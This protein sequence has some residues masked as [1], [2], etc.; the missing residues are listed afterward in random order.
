MRTRC[1]KRVLLMTLLVV[2]F[3]VPLATAQ[4]VCCNPMEVGCTCDDFG[5]CYETP[6]P[7]VI[8]LAGGPWRF[9]GPTHGVRFDIRAIGR[10]ENVSWTTRDANIGFL[11]LDLNGNGVID[12][13]SEL[14]GD[15]TRLSNGRRA[16]NGFA[17]L[18]QY[19]LNS[20]GVIDNSDPVWPRLLLWTDNNHD[21]VSQPEEFERVS[22]SGIT[23]IHLEHHWT[24][25][26]D[27]NGN[28]FRYAGTIDVGERVST[29]YDIYLVL[30]H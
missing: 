11:A 27:P 26:V 2:A 29:Y 1:A 15:A 13:G 5:C 28:R 4:C 19:D 20:D 18:A 6:T 3:T 17:A 25:R 24:G 8:N 30:G 16:G 7:L 12:D 9:T 10:K 14:F 21:G 22:D 23:A